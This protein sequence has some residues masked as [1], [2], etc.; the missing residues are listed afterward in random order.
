MNE[1]RKCK[2]SKGFWMTESQSS[3]DKP[4]KH[5]ANKQVKYMQSKNMGQM[6]G[7][8]RTWKD[9]VSDAVTP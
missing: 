2:V 1:M 8:G 3:L 7:H 9:S 6:E 5:A 4:G